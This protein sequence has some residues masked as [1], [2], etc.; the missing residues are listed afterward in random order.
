MGRDNHPRKI[1]GKR[2][3]AGYDPPPPPPKPRRPK[4]VD[5][6]KE[7]GIIPNNDGKT[8]TRDDVKV[9]REQ[10]RDR[11]IS[12]EKIAKNLGRTVAAVRAEAQ[13]KNIS[14]KPKNR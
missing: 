9:L 10:A 4:G 13:R 14:L 3:K 8:W 1:L 7:R 5:V 11:N 6:A 2:E 12:T